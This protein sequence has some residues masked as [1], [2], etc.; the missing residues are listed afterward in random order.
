MPLPVSTLKEAEH[1]AYSGVALLLFRPA[2]AWPYKEK[3]TLHKARC[4]TMALVSFLYMCCLCSLKACIVPC[5]CSKQAYMFVVFWQ[6]QEVDM[7]KLFIK[8]LQSTY[9]MA[10]CQASLAQLLTQLIFS[11][12][13]W[14]RHVWWSHDWG[15]WP[16]PIT[17]ILM[18]SF[19]NYNSPVSLWNKKT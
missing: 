16:Q 19:C 7:T 15:Q 5:V 6:I 3:E 18:R 4:V 11:E 14:S 17:D 9:C 1:I 12:C 10:Q 2:Q 8:F 13:M